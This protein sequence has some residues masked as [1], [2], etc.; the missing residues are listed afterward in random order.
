MVGWVY[1]RGWGWGAFIRRWAF[2]REYTV[3]YCVVS[4]PSRQESASDCKGK[5]E[6]AGQADVLEEPLILT[7]WRRTKTINKL[8]KQYFVNKS[9]IF[10]KIGVLLSL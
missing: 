2:I 4:L 10:L 3:Y 1:E 5:R 8:N 9:Q 6:R 7:V